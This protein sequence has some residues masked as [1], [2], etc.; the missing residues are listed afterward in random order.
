MGLKKYFFSILI[1]SSISAQSQKLELRHYITTD[2][3]YNL[4]VEDRGEL[5]IYLK[6]YEPGIV[7]YSQPA[8]F[9]VSGWYQLQ[10]DTNRTKL[11]GVYH[12]YLSLELFVP[13]NADQDFL[14]VNENGLKIDTSQFLEKFY[15]PLE[16]HKSKDKK[17]IWFDG[18]QDWNISNIDIDNKNRIHKIYLITNKH[19]LNDAVIDITD[20]IVSPFGKNNIHLEDFQPEIYQQYTDHLGNTHVLLFIMNE[21]V[22]MASLS[23]GGF[24]YL[25]IDDNKII[26]ETAYFETYNHNK[27]EFVLDDSLV[28][29]SKKQFLIIDRFNAKNILGSFFIEKAKFEIINNW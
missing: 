5:F 7:D 19:N 12:P 4:N 16:H 13:I 23:S 8:Y 6:L 2:Q 1:F 21:Y 9:F 26:R 18:L 17:A 25:N 10:N 29:K 20:F 14:I 22:T 15:F 3:I 11:N 24:F 27:Y 28:V